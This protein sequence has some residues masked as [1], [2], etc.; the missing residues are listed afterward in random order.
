[1]AATE[2]HAEQIETTARDYQGRLLQA[3]E[4]VEHDEEA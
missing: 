1:M 4:I 2:G 3:G